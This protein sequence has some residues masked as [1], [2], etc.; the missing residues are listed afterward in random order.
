MPGSPP[1]P[2]LPRDAAAPTDAWLRH[3]AVFAVLLLGLA[4]APAVRAY[5]AVVAAGGGNHQTADW[6]IG[7][8]AGPGRRGLAGEIFLRLAPP[9]Q[10]GLWWLF[11][12]QV[13]LYAVTVA[14]LLAHLVRSRFSWSSIALVL[15]P[16][17]VPFAGWDPPGAFRKEILIFAALALI[18]WAGHAAS[19]RARAA[20][21]W[22]GVVAFVLAAF[23]WEATYAALPVALWLALRPG[24][25]RLPGR[26]PALAATVLA[27]ASVG[28]VALGLATPGDA[29]TA[30]ALCAAVRDHGLTA[31]DL[32]SG[33]IAWMGYDAGL[34]RYQVDWFFPGSLRFLPLA[35]LSLLALITA[36]WT[37]RH[38]W[39]LLATFLGLAPLFA[40]AVDWGRWLHLGVMVGA[41]AVASEDPDA[42]DGT[43]WTGPGAL[44][45]VGAWGLPHSLGVAFV[46]GATGPV[47]AALTTLAAAAGG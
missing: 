25:S 18:G 10:P 33:A 2:T 28:A 39:L 14:F 8:A 1:T 27:T 47:T 26:G 3:R 20:L 11:G 22:S 36:A 23:S 32:C 17:A 21:V 24:R 6:L 30:A 34:G 41:L 45:Y 7:Y 46:P 37:R 4:L 43:V 38:P 16:A 40:L 12:V 31:P 35:G 19:A 5:A 9:G 44:A 29:D 15:G 42:A 13:G